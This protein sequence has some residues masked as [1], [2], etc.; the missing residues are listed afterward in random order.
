VRK[1]II[2][3]LT[4][5]LMALAVAPAFAGTGSGTS[6]DC[7]DAGVNQSWSYQAV[8]ASGNPT[9]P[10]YSGV[11][12]CTAAGSLTAGQ[13]SDSQTSGFIVADGN[14]SNPAPSGGY[15][16]VGNVDPAGAGNPGGIGVVASSCGNYTPGA[17]PAANPGPPETSCP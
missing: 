12:V 9:G 2:T 1:L 6:G 10:T 11:Q 16:G 4:A 15:A 17:A 7:G 8:D 3:G 5:G 13:S 14:S